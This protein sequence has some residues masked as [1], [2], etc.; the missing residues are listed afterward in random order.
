MI[1]VRAARRVHI[2]ATPSPHPPGE[3]PPPLP[4]LQAAG[5]TAMFEPGVA[6]FSR[7]CSS[8]S[9]VMTDVVHRVGGGGGL[10]VRL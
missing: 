6:N 4:S 2:D 5:V 10:A 7:M 9:L 3:P 8:T 1:T